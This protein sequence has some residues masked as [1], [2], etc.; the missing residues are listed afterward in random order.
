[1]TQPSTPTLTPVVGVPATITNLAL[2]RG[3]ATFDGPYLGGPVGAGIGSIPF[4]WDTTSGGWKNSNTDGPL[5]LPLAR[6]DVPAAIKPQ[7]WL[8]IDLTWV[9][10]AGRRQSEQLRFRPAAGDDGQLDLTRDQDPEAYTT[11]ASLLALTAGAEQAAAAANAAAG[12]VDD[13]IL[14]LEAERQ[15]VADIIADTAQTEAQL[16]A[17]DASLRSAANIT[18]YADDSERTAAAPANGTWARTATTGAYH[19]REGSAWV[20]K[21]F[22]GGGNPDAARTQI[23]T[24]TALPAPTDSHQIALSATTDDLYIDADGAWQRLDWQQIVP[25]R[26]AAVGYNEGLIHHMVTDGGGVFYDRVAQLTLLHVRM[27]EATLATNGDGSVGGVLKAG[28]RAS[29]GTANTTSNSTTAG[30]VST[31]NPAGPYSYDALSRVSKTAGTVICKG[32]SLNVEIANAKSFV[33]LRTPNY[34]AILGRSSTRAISLDLS[35]PGGTASYGAIEK[36]A[37]GLYNW[38]VQPEAG[39]NIAMSYGAYMS[40][41]VDSPYCTPNAT[42]PARPDLGTEQIGNIFLGAR[43][44]GGRYSEAAFSEALIFDRQLTPSRIREIMGARSRDVRVTIKPPSGVKFG[45]EVNASN[46]YHPGNIAPRDSRYLT[47]LCGQFRGVKTVRYGVAWKD[48]EPTQ[49]AAYYW[50]AVDVKLTEARALGIPDA[51]IVMCL[52]DAPTWAAVGDSRRPADTSAGGPFAAFVAAFAARYPGVTIE[53]WNEPNLSKYWL[54]TAEAA[55]WPTAAY[56]SSDGTLRALT[57]THAQAFMAVQARAYAVIKSINPAQQVALAPLSWAA[58]YGY[59]YDYLTDCAAYGDGSGYCDSLG[60]HVG[61]ESL[62]L[63][64]EIDSFRSHA[65]LYPAFRGKK[66]IISELYGF[67]RLNNGPKWPALLPQELRSAYSTLNA[68]DIVFAHGDRL[69]VS[70]VH[71]F[72]IASFQTNPLNNNYGMTW[73]S[74]RAANGSSTLKWTVAGLAV[75]RYLETSPWLTPIGAAYPPLPTAY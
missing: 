7:G 72:E 52:Y 54:T 22:S 44:G 27:R 65:D 21:G 73:D 16:L 42:T 69:G 39:H 2:L 48:I 55:A 60:L 74:Q 45:F 70:H 8:Y 57:T 26:A 30:Y 64:N 19:R 23:I 20:F 6:T 11:T 40:A 67:N 15:A 36:G 53:P 33:A 41:F 43:D 37:T 47:R 71:L 3:Q 66:I 32:I 58:F 63:L 12:R 61:N 51:D 24:T 9:D 18:H 5:E 4:E 56:S 1:M 34:Y 75:R 59:A 14:D 25:D 28:R 50:E 49:G 31:Y 29:F 35:G 62:N 10:E 13:A 68:L 17:L 38:G 46:Q